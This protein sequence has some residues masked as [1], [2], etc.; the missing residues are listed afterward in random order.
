MSKDTF[1]TDFYINYINSKAWK[2]I[3]K[4]KLTS[5]STC[6]RCNSNLH[7]HVH[8]GTYDRL[9]NERQ[10][11][12]FVLCKLCHEDVHRKASRLRKS[13]PLLEVT[14]EIIK[15]VKKRKLL[16]D[17]KLKVKK[18]RSSNTQEDELFKPFKLKVSK[19][20]LVNSKEKPE[21]FLKEYS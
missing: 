13:K 14:I 5:Q 12:L 16:K 10:T 19:V 21:S 6:E 1:H 9:G 20:A 3:R 15:G 18:V 17:E 4:Q 8:H 11:D 2:R 7:L